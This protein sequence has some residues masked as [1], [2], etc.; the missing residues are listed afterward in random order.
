[1]LRCFLVH[2]ITA[3]TVV[4]EHLLNKQ[5]VFSLFLLSYSSCSILVPFLFNAPLFFGPL[6]QPYVHQV[7]QI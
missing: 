4:S 5:I 6:Y 3:L 2:C 7:C 1:M